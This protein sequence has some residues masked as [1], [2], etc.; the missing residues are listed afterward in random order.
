MDRCIA[1]GKVPSHGDGH[2]LMTLLQEAYDRTAV[3]GATTVLLV[4]MEDSRHLVVANVGDCGLLMLRPESSSSLHLSRQF[5]TEEV[6]YEANKPA[7]VMRFANTVPAE[8][9][10]V[11]QGARVNSVSCNRGD[12]LVLGSDG[13]FDNLEDE[14]IAL[15]VEGHCMCSPSPDG[16]PAPEAPAA[17]AEMSPTMGAPRPERRCLHGSNSTPLQRPLSTRR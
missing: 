5:R 1:A 13:I 16:S 6:R 9:H 14:E 3:C 15:I 11:I 2:W 12:L 17:C 4:A 8:S 7:Q 10:L